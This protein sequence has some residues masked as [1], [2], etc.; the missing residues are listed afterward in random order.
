MDTGGLFP[1]GQ[2]RQEREADHSSPVS[3]KLN[4]TRINK[5]T[6]QYAFME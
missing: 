4:K 6:P 1:K 2:R 3:A 5:S